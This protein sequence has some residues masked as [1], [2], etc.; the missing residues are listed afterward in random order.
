VRQLQRSRLPRRAPTF[1]T[2]SIRSRGQNGRVVLVPAHRSGSRRV[3]QVLTTT[4]TV[5]QRRLAIVAAL[6]QGLPIPSVPKQP[7]IPPVRDDMVHP[8]SELRAR[9]AQRIERQEFLRRLTPACAIASL[10]RPTTKLAVFSATFSYRS[11]PGGSYGRRASR[12]N[13]SRSLPRRA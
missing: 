12:H 5:L 9:A 8:R 2:G 11:L 4:E 1:R 3:S 10:S 13:A 6:A 7:L